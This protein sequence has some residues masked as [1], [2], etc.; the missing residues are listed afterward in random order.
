MVVRS[1]IFL[2]FL[3][4]LQGSPAWSQVNRW[5]HRFG[6]LGYEETT[7][8][9]FDSS[10]NVIITGSFVDTLDFGGGPLIGAGSRD[11]YLVKLNQAGNHLWSERFGDPAWQETYS[12]ATDAL[13]SIVITGQFEGTVDF[14]GGVLTSAG[15]DD[16]V[17]VAKFDEAG[18]HLW[19]KRFGDGSWQGAR[20]ITTDGFGGIV[21]TGQ[22]SG[23]VDFGGGPLTDN[24]GTD[25]AFLTKF[26]ADGN[27][28]W[29]RQF[30]SAVGNIAIV[31]YGVSVDPSGNVAVAGVMGGIVDFGGGPLTSAGHQDV[32]VARFDPNGGHLWS[33]RFGDSEGQSAIS[34]ATDVSGNVF[35]TGSFHG[36][37][38]FGG[39]PLTTT[40]TGADVFLVKFDD[41]GSHLWSDGFGNEYEQYVN[42]LAVNASGTSVIVGEF[43]ERVDF[44]GG[45]LNSAG[46]WDLF[47]AQ[48][49]PNG[50]HLWSRRFGDS[51]PQYGKGVA[52]DS[53]DKVAITGRFHSTVDFGG[54]PL[55]SV[56][57][58][59]DIYAAQFGPATVSTLLRGFSAT[60]T[61]FGIVVVW[62][63]F[64]LEP[65]A[66]FTVLRAEATGPYRKLHDA[67]I[68]KDGL[69]F[70]F[71]DTS[72]V[73]GLTYRYAVEL[74]DRNGRRILFETEDISTPKLLLLLDQNYPNPFNPATTITYSIPA[75]G[76]VRLRIYDSNG[77][78]VR[79]LVNESQPLK[80]HTVTWDGLRDSGDSVASGIYFIRLEFDGQIRT[81][82][83]AF[84]K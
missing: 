69:S 40:G 63:L 45:T 49:D 57:P 39:G 8:I 22:F 34:T 9:V 3:I 68:T 27:H 84:V 37:V 67:E 55:T 14:G 56:D 43:T 47:L 48:F 83:I 25:D 19:S 46:S 15:N 41:A 61:D 7:E 74:S 30:G 10:H 77:R 12:V 60:Y 79:A 80:V 29:S 71:V 21:I 44:G 72:Y 16:D 31:G 23:T 36:T 24:G 13:G 51:G 6:G 38:N 4:M 26:D 50:G 5:S 53:S 11:I 1:S 76:L 58:F 78:L 66:E 54:G 33:Q 75:S 62:E 64:E 52:I 20:R 2:I 17:F 70:R 73:P 18:N 35:V 42:C 82:K 81:S 65:G 28:L 59:G 32:F